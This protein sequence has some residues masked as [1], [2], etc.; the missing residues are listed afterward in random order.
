MSSFTVLSI[1]L[2]FIILITASSVIVIFCKIINVSFV[3]LNNLSRILNKLLLFSILLHFMRKPYKY[4]GRATLANYVSAIPHTLSQRYT[5][6]H[7]G[8]TNNLATMVVRYLSHTWPIVLSP[9][10]REDIRGSD[11]R[12]RRGRNRGWDRWAVS[13]RNDEAVKRET[14]RE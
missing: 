13:V 11:S 1:I 4:H 5:C 6:M 14:A 12:A 7:T 2:Y 3:N 10:I 9:G 8:I